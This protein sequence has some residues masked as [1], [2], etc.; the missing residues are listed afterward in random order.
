MRNRV[1]FP[2]LAVLVVAAAVVWF[3]PLREH[4]TR[5]EIR[6][7]VESVR[8]AWYAPLLL[9]VMY[10]VGCVFAVPA[11]LFIIAAGAIWGW[12]IGGTF[13]MAGGLLG[14]MAT[15]FVGRLLGGEL[16]ERHGRAR[17]L[18]DKHLRGASFRSLLIVRLLPIFPFA[19]LNYGAGIARVN[20]TAFVF[21][22]LLGLIPSNYVFAWSADEI[23]NGTVSGRGVLSRLFV[24]AAVSVAAVV[25]PSIVA[26]ARHAASLD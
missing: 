16:P 18:L 7:A 3:S 12:V 1:R 9:I 5:D 13:A 6:N 17:R 10:A 14:A 2:L 23:F 11:S 22:T 24:V 26:R 20:T 19:A 15:F 8:A 25:I 4:L 21:S